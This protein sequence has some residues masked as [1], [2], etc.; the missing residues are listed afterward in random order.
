TDEPYEDFLAWWETVGLVIPTY[1][2]DG[3]LI[4]K[5][6]ERWVAE[7]ALWD[8]RDE[9]H[10]LDQGMTGVIR[11]YRGRGIAMALKVRGARLARALGKREI[12]T[13]NDSLNVPILRI[14][15]AL[16]F[17]RESARIT[18]ELALAEVPDS[19]PRSSTGGHPLDAIPS[20]Q[21]GAR[22]PTPRE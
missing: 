10:A 17:K 9:P 14:N 5:D 7:S 12:R 15:E 19:S 18:F 21:H 2:P 16:G 3:Y 4:A 11:A 20:A 6:G 22:K 13:G 8:N 1:L